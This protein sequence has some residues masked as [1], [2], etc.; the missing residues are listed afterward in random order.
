MLCLGLS[1]VGNM[2]V[3]VI[4]ILFF[5]RKD[6]LREHMQRMHNP[7]REAKKADRTGRTKAFKPRLASTDYE[8]FMF[9][10]RMCMMGFRRRGMLVS[11]K[12]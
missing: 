1:V 8:S 3:W 10:C 12:S 6:K 2:A 9:K 7:E 4:Q 11:R 5:Q